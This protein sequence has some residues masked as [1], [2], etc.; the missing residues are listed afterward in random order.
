MSETIVGKIDF[1]VNVD[2]RI[3]IVI[4]KKHVGTD[5][6]IYILEK[7][8]PLKIFYNKDGQTVLLIKKGVM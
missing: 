5:Y 1:V 8:K 2:G 7:L 3:S 6:Y 4:P